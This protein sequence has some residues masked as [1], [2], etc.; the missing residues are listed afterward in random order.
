MFMASAH[1]KTLKKSD[2]AHEDTHIWQPPARCTA[3]RELA[4]PDLAFP[5][6]PT[7]PAISL[8]LSLLQFSLML[9]LFLLS[10]LLLSSPHSTIF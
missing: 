10:S 4:A 8:F 3:R 2:L 6:P 7:P 9:R 5:W 1:L